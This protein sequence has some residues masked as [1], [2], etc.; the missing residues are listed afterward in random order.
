MSPAVER[1]SSEPHRDLARSTSIYIF[2]FHLRSP[3]FKLLFCLQRRP[4]P[5]RARVKRLKLHAFFGLHLIKREVNPANKM[6]RQ[7]VR[8]AS[9][10]MAVVHSSAF[11]RSPSKNASQR[12]TALLMAVRFDKAA[13]KWFTDDPEEMVGSSYGPIGS[14]YRA[15]PKPFLQHLL[16]PETYD[17]AVLKYMAQAGCD[18]TEAQGNMDAFLENPQDWACTSSDVFV[19]ALFDSPTK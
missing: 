2:S 9:L 3:H 17:Q 11:V 5:L 14:L 8:I 16:N 19:V 13:G 6:N 1:R 10:L 7:I 15:G 18:R 4:P 12:S